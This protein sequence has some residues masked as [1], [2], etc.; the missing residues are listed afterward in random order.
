MPRQDVV[1][2][3][4]ADEMP[5]QART[6]IDAMHVVGLKRLVFASSMGIYGGDVSKHPG[7]VSGL[8]G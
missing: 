6:I 1:H 4:L 3:N 2:A 7:S 5:Q 8:G